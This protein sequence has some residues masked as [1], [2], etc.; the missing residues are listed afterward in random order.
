[1]LVRDLAV[2]A[3]VRSCAG[4]PIVRHISACTCGLRGF[5]CL[6]S[7]LRVGGDGNFRTAGVERLRE[8][9]DEALRRTGD[10]REL[11]VVPVGADGVVDD[12]PA[13]H[14]GVAVGLAR[15]DHAIGGFPDR[16]FADVA[17]AQLA[18]SLSRER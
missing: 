11:H 8:R 3:C 18:L 4:P 6:R 16:H 13:L 7:G 5:V 12:G 10:Q 15:E 14:G 17:D 1:M 2:R 9:L